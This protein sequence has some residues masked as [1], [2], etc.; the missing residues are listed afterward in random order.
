M[1][2][3]AGRISSEKNQILCELLRRIEIPNV[4]IFVET[5]K[6]HRLLLVLRGEGLS[7]DLND[8]ES[9]IADKIS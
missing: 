3:R 9:L 5:V 7:G 2:R 6:E 1:D 8:T 4:K